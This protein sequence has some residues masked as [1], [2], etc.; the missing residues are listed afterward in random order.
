VLVPWAR[1]SRYGVERRAGI[2]ARTFNLTAATNRFDE[3]AD[4]ILASG[5]DILAP[6]GGE[7]R[8]GPTASSEAQGSYPHALVSADTC[9]GPAL[10]G[11]AAVADRAPGDHRHAQAAHGVGAL[12][13]NNVAFDLTG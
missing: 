10:A 1:A 9:F 3:I 11:E 13:M 6:A 8:G 12:R 4:F 7:L 5:A 2:A